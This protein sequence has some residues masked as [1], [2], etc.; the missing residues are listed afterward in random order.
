MNTLVFG[1][2]LSALLSTTSLFIVLFRVSPL[3]APAQALFAFFFSA[4]LSVTT[5]STLLLMAIWKKVPGLTWDTGKLTSICL[6]Q[7]IF[8]GI[9]TTITALFLVL[10]L[11]TWWIAILIYGV[12]LL[13]ELALEH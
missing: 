8:L 10:Q 1:I 13:V 9:A 6:R 12:F 4:L 7:G 3:L 5:V 2:S 11:L